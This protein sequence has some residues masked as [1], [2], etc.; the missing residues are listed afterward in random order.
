MARQQQDRAAQEATLKTI[1]ELHLGWFDYPKASATYQELLGLARA[2]SDRVSEI[3][4]LQQLA[5]IC[6]YAKQPQQAVAIK[7][8]LAELYLNEAQFTRLPELRMAIASDYESLGL[9]EDAFRNYQEAYASAWSLQQYYR[10][11]EAL[12]KLVALYRSGGQINEALQTSQI[13]LA[14]DERA[15]NLYG[16]MNTYD[17]IGQLYLE[18]GDEPQ[19]LAAFQNGLELAKTLQHQETYFAQQVEQVTQRISTN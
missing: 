6:D 11:G 15:S 3:T 14:A 17:Q 18:R 13:L 9:L 2:K 7:Q 12:R 5:D 10:A 16:M 1:A 4:Y 8:Q 19:A